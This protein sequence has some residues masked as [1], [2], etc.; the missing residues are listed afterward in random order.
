MVCDR[1]LGM[2]HPITIEQDLYDGATCDSCQSLAVEVLGLGF[3]CVQTR[4]ILVEKGEDGLWHAADVR[5][6]RRLKWALLW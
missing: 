6:W 4:Q 1:C 2:V 5:L 3:V